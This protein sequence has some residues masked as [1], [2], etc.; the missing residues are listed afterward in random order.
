MVLVEIIGEPAVGKTH[1]SLTFPK[2][3]L[4][5]TTPKREARVIAYK[6]LGPEAEKRYIHVKKY[7]ELVQAIKSIPDTVKTVIIDTGSDLQGMAANYEIERRDRERLMPF[8]YG[9]V[10]EMVDEDVIEAVVE[11]NRNLVMTAQ[12]DDE[13]VNGQKTGK[14]IP[15]GYKRMAFQA[16]IRLFLYLAPEKGQA[17]EIE[18]SPYGLGFTYRPEATLT[19]KMARKAVV[20]KNRYTD[21]GLTIIENPTAEKIKELIPPELRQMEWVE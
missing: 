15:K 18:I 7:Q 1:L 6:V 20:I 16:D 3:L 2:P 9:R 10:R 12:M 4:I 14:R 5:D 17:G 8:E 21:I 19:T 11:K 13:Y